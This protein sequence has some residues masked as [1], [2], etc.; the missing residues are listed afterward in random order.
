LTVRPRPILFDT[1]IGSDVDDALALGLVLAS[2]AELRLVAVTTV[3][4]HGALRARV[5]AGLLGLAGRDDVETCIGA[6]T[7][8]LGRAGFNWFDHEPRCI[9]AAPPAPISD[10]P[11]AERIVRAAREVPG[12][13]IV[14]IGPMTNLARALAQDPGLAKRIGGVTIMGGHLR[15]VR[16]GDFRAPYGVDYNLCSDPEASMTVLGCGAKITLVP[17]DLTLRVWLDAACVAR[18]EAEGGALAREL[19]RQVRIWAPVQRRVFTGMGGTLAEDN[20]A[21]LHDPLT[22]L[23][24]IDDTGFDWQTLRVLPTIED[25]VL[26]TREVRGEEGLGAEMRVALGADPVACARR[27][28]ERILSR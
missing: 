23:A 11:A 14:M 19:A 26:R 16:I 21:F 22:L 9:A 1:D 28:T 2:P 7:P 20:L 10:E 6:E 12:L 4:R 25:G 15:E 18:M 13:E 27:I 24:S 17:A 3:G 5:A 8:L